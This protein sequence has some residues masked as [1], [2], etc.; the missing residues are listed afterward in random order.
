MTFNAPRD[1]G[2]LV[3]HGTPADSTP[4]I[5]RSGIHFLQYEPSF[6][7][8]L[9]LAHNKYA[10]WGANPPRRYSGAAGEQARELA[11]RGLIPGGDDDAEL[12]RRAADYWENQEGGGAVFVIDPVSWTLGPG[13]TAE[14]VFDTKARE[15]R[16]GL[17]K[18]IYNHRAL[19]EMEGDISPEAQ[20]GY[21]AMIY[22]ELS[23][24]GEESGRRRLAVPPGNILG[25]LPTR[26][27]TRELLNRFAREVAGIPTE[28]ET[29]DLEME[30]TAALAR[31][32]LPMQDLEE[33]F[34]RSTLPAILL[35]Q[36]K[37]NTLLVALKRSFLSILREMGYKMIKG[38]YTVPY[39]EDAHVFFTEFEIKAHLEALHAALER[40]VGATRRG[41]AILQLL[42]ELQQKGDGE[43]RPIRAYRELQSL[44]RQLK[45]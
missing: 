36:M 9:A 4:G 19:Y 26:P 17:T 8:D 44:E 22:R 33:G 10:D 20:S 41:G 29:G 27:G 14:L 30:L 43:D 28:G 40:E 18:W 7:T 1:N 6:T 32:F 21:R 3:L 5:L 2:P 35:S 31:D 39:E 13:P 15:V 38:D 37:A 16:G 45:I 24:P 12:L 25:R 23:K 11:R 34:L 42:L